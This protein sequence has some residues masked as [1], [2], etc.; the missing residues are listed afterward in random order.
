MLLAAS[1]CALKSSPPSGLAWGVA[2]ASTVS[3]G[4]LGYFFGGWYTPVAGERPSFEL[5][6]VPLFVSILAPVLG[7]ALF[8]QSGIIFAQPGLQDGVLWVVPMAVAMTLAYFTVAWPVAIAVFVLAGVVL[9]VRS[10]RGSDQSFKPTS[11][12][13]AA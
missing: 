3:A 11:L 13:D 12:R 9:G 6:A 2:A 8:L 7:A 4:T 5:V 1:Y 10:W